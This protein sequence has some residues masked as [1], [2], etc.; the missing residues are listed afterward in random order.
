M[1]GWG[2]RFG[3]VMFETRGELG[4]ERPAALLLHG[5]HGSWRH[6]QANLDHIAQRFDVLIPDFPGYGQSCELPPEAGLDD[7]ASALE[8][9]VDAA[10]SGRLPELVVGFSFGTV[11]GTALLERWQAAGR[12]PRALVLVNPPLGREVSAQVLEIQ[13]RAAQQ[14]RDRGLAAAMEITLREIMLSD[15]S[16]LSDALIELGVS[17]VKQA[18]FKSRPI[19]RSIDLRERLIQLQVPRYVILGDRDPHQRSRLAERV[20]QYRDL[21]GN[22][23]VQVL[24]GAHWLQYDAP[25]QFAVALDAIVSPWFEGGAQERASA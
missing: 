19:S 20:P 25:D 22:D 4:G 3:R 21:F 16:K 12:W 18:R 17:Q 23:H 6:W 9:S 11:V 8:Q 10:L 2:S 1:R 5:G 14:A 13:A 24:S 15:H 7:L